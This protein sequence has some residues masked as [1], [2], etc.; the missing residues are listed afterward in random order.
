[1]SESSLKREIFYLKESRAT[2]LEM[3]DVLKLAKSALQKT[4]SALEEKTSRLQR[5]N[6]ILTGSVSSLK[7]MVFM[8]EDEKDSLEEKTSRLQREKDILTGSVSSLKKMV[9]MYEDEKD[10]LEEKTSRLQREKDILT[11]SVSSLKKMV[12][13]YE[14]EKDSL[15]EKTSKLQ[16]EKDILDERVVSLEKDIVAYRDE[17]ASMEETISALEK[18]IPIK[19]GK[20]LVVKKVTEKDCPL[21]RHMSLKHGIPQKSPVHASLGTNKSLL[22]ESCPHIMDLD[23]QNRS[24]YLIQHGLCRVCIFKPITAHH[25]EEK[26]RFLYQKERLKC[27]VC[28]LKLSVCPEHK[29]DNLRSLEHFKRRFSNYGINFQF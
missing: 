9:F 5:E 10:S 18:Q 13:M 15:E 22:A 3:T 8:Y 7:K 6:D 16:K 2:L 25:K 20:E 28:H 1:M 24:E 23:I 19:L 29:Q 11:G 21:C 26:C 17:K 12:F 27:K 14:D 4:N